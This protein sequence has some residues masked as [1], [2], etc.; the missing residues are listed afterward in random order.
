MT[1]ADKTQSKVYKIYVSKTN[2][3]ELANTNLETLAIENTLL[4]PPFVPLPVR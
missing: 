3:L 4:N 2:N 1:S